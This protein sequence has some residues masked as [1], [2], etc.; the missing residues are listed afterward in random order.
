MV[1]IEPIFL[2]EDLY[3]VKLTV[4]QHPS[5]SKSIKRRDFWRTREEVSDYLK[6][7]K[8][9]EKWDGEV[10]DLYLHY[11]F[12][13][14]ASG[15]YTLSCSPRREASLFMGGQH[16]DPWPL[17]ETVLCPVLVV[18]GSE[19]ENR[20]FID[21][22]KAASMFGNGHYRLIEGAG[23]LIPMERPREIESIIR[24]FFEGKQ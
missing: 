1:L 2:P 17:L 24:D 7:R 21:L 9:F 13:G 20:P 5:A 3:R 12:A 10:L 18:E 14:G 11:G 22:K 15:G 19:S 4:E 8:L 23:H 6:S 16:C